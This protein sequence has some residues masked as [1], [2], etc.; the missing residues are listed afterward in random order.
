[1]LPLPHERVNQPTALL[2][3]QPFE[4]TAEWEPT[5]GC[6]SS[7][8][9]SSWPRPAALAARPLAPLVRFRS[10]ASSPDRA[11]QTAN[12]GHMQRVRIIDLSRGLSQ[13]VDA[14][15]AVCR[16]RPAS[17][18]SC[19]GCQSGMMHTAV[20]RSARRRCH[21]A[22][23]VTLVSGLTDSSSC[24]AALLRRHHRHILPIHDMIRGVY[25]RQ[26][27]AP[28]ACVASTSAKEA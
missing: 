13:V 11:A 2:N 3:T 14:A 17:S 22:V 21:A 10:P 24:G 1:M 19:P 12:E 28:A 15:A 6:S 20:P 7:V 9:A 16:I 5:W 25:R 27:R 23:L 18:E 8:A 26:R 4:A